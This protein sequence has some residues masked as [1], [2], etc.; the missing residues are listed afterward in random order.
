M[1][2]MLEV[3]GPVIICC[4]AFVFTLCI[5]YLI[6]IVNVQLVAGAEVFC[7]AL[8]LLNILCGSCAEMSACKW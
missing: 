2:K 6:D 4:Q 7:N 8:L 1:E 5:S 3:R